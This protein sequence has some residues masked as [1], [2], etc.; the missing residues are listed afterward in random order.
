MWVSIPLFFLSCWTEVRS[1]RYTAKVANAASS[2]S[3]PV[4]SPAICVGSN[5]ACD[6]NQCCPGFE[7]SLHK[8]FPCPNADDNFD[9]CESGFKYDLY[10]A[11]LLDFSN[12]VY[13]RLST[14]LAD[15][16]GEAL[17]YGVGYWSGQRLDIKVQAVDT[18]GSRTVLD[19]DTFKAIKPHAEG[20]LLRFDFQ[21]R[22]KGTLKF[23]T[24]VQENGV[25]TPISLPWMTITLMDFDCGSNRNKCERVSSADHSHYEA[26]SQVKVFTTSSGIEFGDSIISNAENNPHSVVLDDVQKSISAGLVFEGRSEFTLGMGNYAWWPRTI[27]LAGICNLQWPEIVTPAPTPSP[28]PAPTPSPTEAPTSTPRPTPSPTCPLNLVSGDCSVSCD[29][30]SSPN[31]PEKYSA[32]DG[33]QINLRSPSTLDVSDFN[34]EVFWDTLK[35]NGAD[36][37]GTDGPDRVEAR[38]DIIWSADGASEEKGWHFCAVLPTPKPTPSPTPSPT[39]VIEVEEGP[40]SVSGSCVLSPNYPLN[41][42][43]R[44]TCKVQFNS[45]ETLHVDHFTT[46]NTFDTLVLDGHTYTGMN[47][48][49]QV[50]VTPNSVMTWES[51]FTTTNKGWMICTESIENRVF[52][53]GDPHVSTITGDSFDLWRTGWS[54]F[55]KIP[56]EVSEQPDKLLVRGEVRP[57]G[58][59]PCAPSFLQQVRING[60]W[61]GGHEVS[62]QGGSLESSSP[63]NVVREGSGPMFLRQE[64]VTEFINEKGVSLRGWIA[65]DLGV[66]GPDA[67]VELTVGDANVTIVQHTEGRGESSNAMLDLSVSGLESI[68][69]TI[70]GWLG[71]DGAAQAGTAPPECE[72][73]GVAEAPRYVMSQVAKGS[74]ALKLLTM[75]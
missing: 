29:C 14:G 1:V 32:H 15:N 7:G 36:Y 19:A 24:G 60:S 37:S 5:D 39:P 57:Y 48:P 44:E 20:R 58:G 30:A 33:C 73:E 55:V 64:G 38:G 61:L 75:G 72:G 4:P 70:G 34:T 65:E 28:T 46:E 25:W 31:Y 45:H 18:D 68:V 47:G 43:S 50:A 13:D 67:R 41:Y 35:V 10:N 71:V 59:S 54:T 66:W 3:S 62:V 9:G 2:R 27:L 56:L 53:I 6:G 26:G 8:T 11:S 23:L 63:F 49:D 17:F 22:G 69:D 42:G 74:G 16:D 12:V 51:D 21:G 40:C 52:A